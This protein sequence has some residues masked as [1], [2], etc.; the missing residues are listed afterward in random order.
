MY[1]ADLRGNC[2]TPTARDQTWRRQTTKARSDISSI[3]HVLFFLVGLVQARWREHL[4]QLCEWV[5][6]LRFHAERSRLPMRPGGMSLANKSP[7][8]ECAGTRISVI[9]SSVRTSPRT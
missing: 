9:P 8:S 7:I 4:D 5:F 2:Q 1:Q 3:G 6:C